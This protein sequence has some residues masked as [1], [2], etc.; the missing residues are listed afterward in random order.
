MRYG[1]PSSLLGSSNPCQCTDVET[2]ILFVTLILAISPSVNLSVGP[3]TEPLMDI[4]ITS[5]PVK[6][7]SLFSIVR[8]YSTV[9]AELPVLKNCKSKNVNNIFFIIPPNHDSYKILQCTKKYVFIQRID[10]RLNRKSLKHISPEESDPCR[11][12]L[13]F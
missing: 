10:I 5:S 4:A 12:P 13:N 1:T 2:F 8:L 11:G 7:R 6:L 9:S 3:G